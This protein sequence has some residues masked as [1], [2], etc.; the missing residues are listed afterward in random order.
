MNE[1]IKETKQPKQPIIETKK[2]VE[3]VPLKDLTAEIVEKFQK[4]PCTFIDDVTKKGYSV[5]SIAFK[6]HDQFLKEVKLTQ[7]NKALSADRFDLIAL[8]IDLPRLDVYGRPITQWNR[9]AFVR[10]VKGL[11]DDGREYFSIELIFKKGVY[12]THFFTSDQIRI[13]NLLEERKIIDIDWVTRPD[14]I[15]LEEDSED[16]DF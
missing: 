14:A 12:H 16:L 4:V 15:Q 2:E 13:L 8:S 5:K 9:N 6:I 3:F 10:F 7:N 1:Q 11:I